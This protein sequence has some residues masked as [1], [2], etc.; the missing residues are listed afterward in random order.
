MG[1]LG[2]LIKAGWSP[3]AAI[4]WNILLNFSAFIGVAFG[5]AIG[6]LSPEIS[7]YASLIVAGAFCY[8]GLTLMLP[9]V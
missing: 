4:C 5:L 8:I 9:V 7:L 6:N 1:A 2:I 3:R